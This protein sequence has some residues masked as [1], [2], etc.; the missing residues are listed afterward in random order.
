MGSPHI[1]LIHPQVCSSVLV[2]WVLQP[3]WIE[4]KEGKPSVVFQCSLDAMKF[5]GFFKQTAEI[6]GDTV[7][8]WNLAP[9]F[10]WCWNPT[11]NGINYLPQLVSRISAINSRDSL[12]FLR[13][14]HVCLY[15]GMLSFPPNDFGNWRFSSEYPVKD[16]IILVVPVTG[17]R[18]TPKVYAY[19]I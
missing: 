12:E 16:V 4:W 10:G 11:N 17:W 6:L 2:I 14:H 18:S 7:D 8:G 5:S 15:I 9:P 13:D 1:I 3:V 19:I